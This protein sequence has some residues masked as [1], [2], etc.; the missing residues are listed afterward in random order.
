MAA[1]KGK[2]YFAIFGVFLPLLA[3]IGA[4]RLAEPGSIWARL[5]YGETSDKLV[6]SL[7]RY[8]I[9]ERDL[10]PLKEWFLDIIGGKPGRPLARKEK[11]TVL[12]DEDDKS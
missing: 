2:I 5:F 8:A 11:R 12:Y 10:R 9:Y 1:L 4:I 6:W 7:E 3:I